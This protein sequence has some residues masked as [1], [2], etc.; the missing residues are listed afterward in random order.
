M[1][2]INE[3]DF[4]LLRDYI[5]DICGISI[6]AEKAYLIETKLGKLMEDSGVD[7]YGDFYRHIASNRDPAMCQEVINAITTNETSWFRDA[8]P[9]KLLEETYLP[10]FVEALSSGRQNR[11]R[12]WCAAVSTGQ[13]A[14]STAICVDDYLDR[15][16]VAG[17]GLADFEFFATDISERVLKIAKRGV[18]DKISISRGLSERYREKYFANK[19][20]EWSINPK[21]RNT[22][23]FRQFNLQDD[24]RPLGRFDVIFCRYALIYFSTELKRD[25]INK[26]RAVL[27]DGGIL[28]TGNYVLYD[29]F[30]DGFEMNHYGNMTY[31]TKR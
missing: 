9:W 29:L 27:A 8:S 10:K 7:A 3:N 22:V 18:Y 31:Y 24:F 4:T 21:I 28:F 12:V 16:H 15:N 30:E 25:V 5:N 23:C 14:Y 11:I 6:P 19:G 20:K 26:M 17:V 13:E 2:H 1:N